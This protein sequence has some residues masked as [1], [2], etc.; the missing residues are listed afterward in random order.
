MKKKFWVSGISALI[1]AVGLSMVA[2]EAA[3]AAGIPEGIYVGGQNLGGMTEE[4]A[5]QTAKDYVNSLAGQKIT[6]DVDGTLVETTAEELGFQWSNPEAVGETIEQYTKGNLIIRFLAA[7]KLARENVEIP[8]EVSVNEE[9]MNAFVDAQCTGLMIPAVNAAIKRENGQFVITPSAVGRAIDLEEAKRILADAL[10]QGFDQ[11]VEV[12]IPVEESQ[13][14]ISEEALA[15]I[16]DVLGSF[17]TGFSSSGAARSKNLS[18][19]AA[20]I[21]GYLLMPGQTLSGYE[22]MQPFTTQNGYATAAA[23]ENGLV[24][25]SVGGGVCQISTTLYNAALKAE[26][27]IT[28]RQNHSMVV[29]YVD[30][31]ADA[32]IAGTYKDIKITNN[33]STPL[34]V[35]GYT[36]GKKLTFTI[37][38]KET[39]PANRKVAYVSET[40]SV[41]D[42]GDPITKVDNGLAPGSTVREQSGHKGV[43][44][45]LWK[46]VTVDGV[47][48]ERTLLH[49]DTYNPSKAI[50]RVG[51]AAP[52]TSP[53]VNPEVPVPQ[54][55]SSE[56][57]NGTAEAPSAEPNSAPSEAAPEAPAMPAAPTAPAAPADPT[58]P[59]APAA[60]E[61][62]GG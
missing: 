52:V 41:T 7:K 57:E 32:A 55:P 45:R 19:G 34:Y 21:N 56:G 47:E 51:P 60:P 44:S 29:G 5:D 59:A 13:P 50:V 18:V 27:E 33:Y 24:V 40:L 23:Y 6:L 48:T 58:A 54:V 43:K 9:K 31:S 1:L 49:T 25:D 4:K 42:P 20:K 37:Y 22:C 10:D 30:H 62:A 15:T 14:A 39:R 61:T 11:P 17:T 28:Q 8:V 38:G 36:T 46:V 3:M 16:G 26:M 12:K 35:E 53:E 2:P